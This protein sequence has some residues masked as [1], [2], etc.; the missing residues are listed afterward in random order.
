MVW[1]ER[2]VVVSQRFPI[3][4]FLPRGITTT[5]SEEQVIIIA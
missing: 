5:P 4:H 2:L 3:Q 1:S